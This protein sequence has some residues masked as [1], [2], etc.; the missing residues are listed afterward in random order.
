MEQVVQRFYLINF[1]FCFYNLEVTN[2]LDFSAINV[3]DVLGKRSTTTFQNLRWITPI[4][5][6][7][8]YNFKFNLLKLVLDLFNDLCVMKVQQETR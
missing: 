3:C 2:I 4:V 5:F 1:K 7:S 8:T 6:N